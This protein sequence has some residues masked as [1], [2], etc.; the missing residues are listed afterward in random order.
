MPRYSWPGRRRGSYGARPSG[1]L[2]CAAAGNDT[3]CDVP[4]KRGEFQEKS[5]HMKIFIHRWPG[6][7]TGMFRNR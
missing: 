4:R 6:I 2:Y 1:H 7:L 3:T 5:V